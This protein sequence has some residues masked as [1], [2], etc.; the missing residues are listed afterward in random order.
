MWVPSHTGIPGN[1]RADSLAKLGTAIDA[2]ASPYLPLRPLTS[3]RG[4]ISHAIMETWPASWTAYPG[5]RMT[6][7]FLPRPNPSWVRP[8][9]ALDRPTLTRCVSFLTGHNN[10]RYHRSLREP[11]TVCLCRFYDLSVETSAHLYAECP[12]FS[13]FHFNTLAALLSPASPPLGLWTSWF[14]SSNKRQFPPLWM[15]LK[16]YRLLLNTTGQT[17]TPTLR[18]PVRVLLLPLYLILILCYNNTC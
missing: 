18:T 17:W 6:K 11:G 10:L 5:G 3:S 9:L 2:P 7:D 4:E 1:K 13:N 15:T 12:C 16:L 14:P 8:L